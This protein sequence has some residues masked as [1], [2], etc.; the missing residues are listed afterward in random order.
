MDISLSYRTIASQHNRLVAKLKLSPP[1]R[2]YDLRH[3]FG[4]MLGEG[5]AGA[6]DIMQLMGHSSVTTS[7]RYVHPTPERLIQAVRQ[8]DDLR[9]RRLEEVNAGM[10]VQ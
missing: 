5:G 2:L 10:T 3:T 7:Q 1:L 4:T 6:F 9:R 8:M